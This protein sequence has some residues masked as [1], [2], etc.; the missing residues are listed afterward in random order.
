VGGFS[1]GYR[2][3]TE[4]VDLGLKADRRRLGR[5]VLGPFDRVSPASQRT[6][7]AQS[8]LAIRDE[9]RPQPSAC[10]TNAGRRRCATSC[11]VRG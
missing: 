2:F 10:F 4:D 11:G 6:Q 3:G 5:A 7:A 9:P 1:D 8:Q